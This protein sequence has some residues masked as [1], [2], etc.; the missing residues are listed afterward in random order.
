MKKLTSI[1]VLLLLVVLPFSVASAQLDEDEN[2]FVFHDGTE[3]E[4]PEDWEVINTTDDWNIN[5]SDGTTIIYFVQ[6]FP[7]E[8]EALDISEA[9][10]LM[11]PQLEVDFPDHDFD[12]DEIEEVEIADLEGVRYEFTYENQDDVE[13]QVV[14]Y[15]VID[16]NDY[17]WVI[18]ILPV[19]DEELDDED[20]ATEIA[21]SVFGEADQDDDDRGGDGEDITEFEFNDGSVFEVPEDWTVTSTTEDYYIELN[22]EELGLFIFQYYP[23]TLEEGRVDDLFEL[24]EFYYSGYEF[25]EDVEFDEDDV[26][27]IEIADLDAVQYAFDYPGDSGD[28]EIVLVATLLDNDYAFVAG[29]FPL[30]GERL[31]GEDDAL[32]IFEAFLEDNQ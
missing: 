30:E 2:V 29:V 28:F 9:A 5:I 26:E 25:A 17:G 16:D 10:D 18:G 21:F 32:E 19:E 14:M 24:I 15:I 20:E 12:D 8:L 6:Y 3:F 11:G 7:E 13:Q 4:I 22:S 31:R 27:E 1:L 23:E